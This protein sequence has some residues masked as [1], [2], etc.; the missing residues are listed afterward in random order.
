MAIQYRHAGKG[1]TQRPVLTLQ[2]TVGDI[3]DTLRRAAQDR[4]FEGS[5]KDIEHEARSILISS[6]I[7]PDNRQALRFDDDSPEAFCDEILT[8]IDIA[9]AAISAGD[10]D[11]IARAGIQIGRLVEAYFIKQEWEHRALLGAKSLNGSRQGGRARARALSVKTAARDLRM[12][13]QFKQKRPHSRLSNTALMSEIGKDEELGRS[14]SNAA[15][16]RGLA[17]LSKLKGSK[18][19]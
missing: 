15:V 14:A 6:G 2:G 18:N 13:R 12:A 9:R 10:A 19:G 11:R 5:I 4:T 7:D 16:K 3:R 8:W 17:S 1:I